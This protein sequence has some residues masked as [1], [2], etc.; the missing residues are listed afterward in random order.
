MNIYL[1][2][3][4]IPNMSHSDVKG[5]GDAYS[6]NDKWIIVRDYFKFVD[7]ID[8]SFDKIELV[9]FDHDLSCFKKV[10]GVKEEFTG[11]TAVDYLI[12]YCLDN[13]KKFPNWYVH[14]DN[15]SGRGNIIGAII[16][17]LKVIEGYDISQFR[18]YHSGIIN[19]KLV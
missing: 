10:Y 17:Y 13:N 11:K 9:S 15:T 2:D 12:N 1:D 6:S 7:L 5:L 3:K 14:T 16:N 19:N 4:R 8:K 18:Y